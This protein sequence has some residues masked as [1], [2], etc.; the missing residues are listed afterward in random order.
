MRYAKFSLLL[1]LLL[2]GN[3]LG[4]EKFAAEVRIEA[5]GAPIDVGSFSGAAPFVG[6]FDG[7]GLNDLLVGQYEQGRLRIYRNMGTRQEPRFDDFE[8][9]RVNGEIVELPGPG[10]FH[11]Q[12]VDLDSDGKLDIVTTSGSGIIFWY[13]RTARNEFADAE[14][15]RLTDGPALVARPNGG[16]HVVDW[17]GD[18]D[19]DLIISGQPKLGA[20]SV[21]VWFVENRGAPPALSLAA[22]RALEAEGE[23]IQSQELEAY[24]FVADWNGD[25]KPDLLLGTRGGSVLLY[26]NTGERRAPKLAQS[27]PLVAVARRGVRAAADVQQHATGGRFCVTDWDN[28]GALDILIGDGQL[29]RVPP[30][31]P[32]TANLLEKTR[33]DTGQIFGEYRRM[34]G[35]QDRLQPGQEK[36]RQLVRQKREEYARRL[37]KL[38]ET[39][40]KL[41][42]AL[43]PRQESHA[44]VWL[45]Q[46]INQ[47]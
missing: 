29:A 23:P 41:E 6:D 39:I 46:G 24:P 35:L 7:D 40:A 32:N 12:L 11:P 3:S 5:R 20:R 37:D 19:N 22:P 30:D 36:Q 18:G 2:A 26:E 44:Y 21:A 16:C 28:D 27:R 31:D 9:F 14:I 47:K 1:F 45:L 15:V 34:R 38:N 8:W 33:Q 10:V 13:R 25:G 42:K 43:E 17:D 4:E